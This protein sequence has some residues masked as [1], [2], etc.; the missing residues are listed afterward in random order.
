MTF[1][2]ALAFSLFPLANTSVAVKRWGVPLP[3]CTDFTP[4]V[5]AGCFT[6]PPSVGALSYRTDLD[7][8]N[9]TIEACVDFC[10]GKV[11]YQ[12]KFVLC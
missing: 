2:T 1:V 7:F 11:P 10:K 12:C 9:M 3:S 6:D 8:N 4:F 5:Y